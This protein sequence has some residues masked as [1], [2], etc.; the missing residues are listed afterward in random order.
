MNVGELYKDGRL[1]EAIE[2][3]VQE[4]K[5][6]P[7]DQAKR[8]F[9]FEL[10]TFGGD[11]E[12]ARRQI[13]AVEYKD[14]GIDA[15]VAVYRKLLDAEQARRDLFAR[16]M[17]PG[18]FGEPSEHLRL[19]LEAINRLRED[20]S[21]EASEVLARSNEAIPTVRGQLNGQ[22]FDSFRDADDLFAGVLEVMAHGRYFWVGLEQV[23]LVTMTAPRF[24]RDLLFI[25]A[26]LELED[27]QGEV[28][29]PALYPRSH[30]HV[31]DQV[32][33][34]RKT[35]WNEL[36]G[37]AMLGVGLHTFLRDDDAI[38]LLEWREWRSDQE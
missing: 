37:G 5:S 32:R 31:D 13:E 7:N 33:L 21:S 15:A 25:P 17:A 30:C 34:G 3:Q 18:F 27:D 14:A 4:V 19:R 8:L 20:R 6:A 29:L 1:G 24:P 23:R 10:L 11:L 35:D 26:H 9:L 28:F 22:A 12:R 36:Y 38:G 16:G 2:A